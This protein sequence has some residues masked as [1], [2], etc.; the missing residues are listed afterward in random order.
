MENLQLAYKITKEQQIAFG[1]WSRTVP[2]TKEEQKQRQEKFLELQ[3][4]YN[5]T[6]DKNI[7]WFEMKP[8]IEDCC[9]SAVIKRNG[10]NGWFP[11]YEKKL[12]DAV[13]TIIMRYAKKQTYNYRSLVTLCYWAALGSSCNKNMQELDKDV[14]YEISHPTVVERLNNENSQGLVETRDFAYC[15]VG[16]DEYVCIEDLY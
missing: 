16:E 11:N 14:L 7:L 12:E 6:G 3:Q 1:E 8:L 2:L 10:K 9:K 5:E 15:S 4:K 13:D